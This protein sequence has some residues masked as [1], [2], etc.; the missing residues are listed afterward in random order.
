MR[1]KDQ[2]RRQCGRLSTPQ[3]FMQNICRG[4]EREERQREGGGC[5]DQKEAT[6][7]HTSLG[8]TLGQDTPWEVSSLLS[9]STF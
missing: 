6:Y 1:I 3:V 8:T 9:V 7:T 2:K 5:V 4:D